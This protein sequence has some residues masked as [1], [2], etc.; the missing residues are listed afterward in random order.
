MKRSQEDP[1]PSADKKC[2]KKSQNE[3]AISASVLFAVP[4][5]PSR[6]TPQSLHLWDTC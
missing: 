3:K 1:R 4:K 6:R 5:F 2:Q